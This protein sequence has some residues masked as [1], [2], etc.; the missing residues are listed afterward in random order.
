MKKSMRIGLLLGTKRSKNHAQLLLKLALELKKSGV[1]VVLICPEDHFITRSAASKEIPVQHIRE[2][3]MSYD[4]AGAL[5][6]RRALKKSKIDTILF[7]DHRETAILVTAKFLMKGKLRLV[8]C[9]AEA[10]APMK[11]DFLHTFRFNQI[12]AWITPYSATALEVKSETNLDH[13]RLHIIPIPFVSRKRTPNNASPHHPKSGAFKIGFVVNTERTDESDQLFEAI[14]VLSKRGVKAEIILA[15]EGLKLNEQQL[16]QKMVETSLRFGYT[17]TPLVANL[18]RSESTFWSECDAIFI[19]LH[20]EP[21]SG[22]SERA[23]ANSIACIAFSSLL[24]KDI[25]A[26]GHAAFLCKRDNVT[27]LAITIEMVMNNEDLRNEITSNAFELAK[28]EL[29]V[30]MFSDHLINLLKALPKK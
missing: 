27:D 1:H 22:V 6:F 17:E 2:F 18:E 3:K 4:F 30:K 25:F 8:Y 7:R 19:G 5:S 23:M 28:K 24:S 21:F 14:S 16:Q 13:D 11:R 15:F 29:S 12:D 26:D 9:Q 10:L 20:S